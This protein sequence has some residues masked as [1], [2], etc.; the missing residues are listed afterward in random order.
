MHF[1]CHGEALQGH[2]LNAAVILDGGQHL[3]PEYLTDSPLGARGRSRAARRADVGGID[4]LGLLVGQ[5]G[6]A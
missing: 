1:A 6:S 3:D 2:P 5:L 4:A